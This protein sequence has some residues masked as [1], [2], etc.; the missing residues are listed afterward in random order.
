MLQTLLRTFRT[1]W[2]WAGLPV[3]ARDEAKKITLSSHD[4][5]SRA[6]SSDGVGSRFQAGRFFFL[7]FFQAIFGGRACVT[8]SVVA[9]VVAVVVCCVVRSN[10]P[11]VLL[12]RVS[13]NAWQSTGHSYWEQLA[14]CK[15]RIAAERITAFAWHISTNKIC[16][17]KIENKSSIA[18]C[19]FFQKLQF[20]ANL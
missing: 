9:V 12:L 1:G 3:A 17:S 13:I 19:Q 11:K 4:W 6:D 20:S 18:I 16:I 2:V 5:S 7:I 10:T 14:N 8:W 15:H